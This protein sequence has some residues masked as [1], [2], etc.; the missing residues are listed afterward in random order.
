MFIGG[1]R[2]VPLI[3]QPTGGWNASLHPSQIADNELSQAYNVVYDPSTGKLTTRQGLAVASTTAL[4]D[5]ITFLYPFVRKDSEGYLMAVAAGVLYHYDFSAGQWVTVASLNNSDTPTMT[6]FNGKLVVADGA[7]G[8]LLTWDGSKVDR[9]ENSPQATIVFSARGRLVCNMVDDLDAVYMC[10]PE[11]ETDWDT[12]DGGAVSIR[13]GFGD[14]MAVNGFAMV[15]GSLIVSKVARNDGAV[16]GKKLWRLNMAAPVSSWAADDLSLSNAAI[17]PHCITGFGNN[18]YYIDSEGFEALAPTQAY[19]DIA[20]DPS[21]GTKVNAV[22]GQFANLA[23]EPMMVKLPSMA[24]VWTLL[25]KTN[26]WSQIYTFSPLGGFTEIGFGTDIYAVAEFGGAVYLAGE[27][28]YL[29]KLQNRA[30][31]EI[32]PGVEKDVVSVARFKMITGPGD[33]LLTKVI[34]QTNF[35]WSG[36]Y[37]IE[38]YGSDELTRRLLQTVDFVRG[39]GADSLHDALYDLADANFPLA[40]GRVENR[41]CRAQFR[42]SGIMLQVR[43]MNGGRM[44]ISE[45]A[46]KLVV[47][48]R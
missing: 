44:S 21:I 46:A 7:F 16:V 11:D 14:G 47:V 19:G 2:E 31:D 41:E 32:E 24:A 17:G 25:T 6:T 29:Y 27:S 28:G 36:T 10:G 39:S 26:G 40:G 30:V 38:V 34:L 13:A 18:V 20:T 8:G 4:G 5:P 33:L 42:N 1:R 48:G 22:L 23:D 45:L 43:T 35:E 3:M 37:N 9:L 15:S 12:T